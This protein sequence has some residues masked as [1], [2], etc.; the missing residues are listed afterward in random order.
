MI[1]RVKSPVASRTLTAVTQ[2]YR[3]TVENQ[4]EKTRAGESLIVSLFIPE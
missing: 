1:A 4:S 3:L 2:V